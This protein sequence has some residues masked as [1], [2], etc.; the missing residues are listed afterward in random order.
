M[1]SIFGSFWWACNKSQQR[2]GQGPLEGKKRLDDLMFPNTNAPLQ[3]ARCG[4]LETSESQ[5][6]IVRLRVHSNDKKKDILGNQGKRVA[7]HSRT[8]KLQY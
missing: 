7:T 4:N 1:G 2:M 8:N 3:T 6:K 5:S